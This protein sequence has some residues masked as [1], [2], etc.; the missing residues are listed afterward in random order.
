M[1]N[2]I[3]LQHVAKRTIDFLANEDLTVAEAKYILE[4][5]VKLIDAE[6]K[7]KV[8]GKDD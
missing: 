1:K 8:I 7:I 3:D 6:T 2:M 5:S 4:F